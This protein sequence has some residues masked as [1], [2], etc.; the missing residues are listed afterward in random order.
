MQRQNRQCLSI[1]MLF[2]I[3][4]PR[5]SSVQQEKE[6]VALTLSSEAAYHCQAN[7]ASITICCF[8]GSAR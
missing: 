6:R 1:E 2:K 5:P 3:A 7:I 4:D 8:S